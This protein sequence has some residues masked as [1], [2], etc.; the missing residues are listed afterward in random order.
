VKYFATQLKLPPEKLKP[1]YE[2]RGAGFKW[3]LAG[4]A[5]SEEFLFGGIWDYSAVPARWKAQ[6]IGFR[7]VKDA[8]APAH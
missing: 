7:C 3:P 8:A 2:I 5:K 6:D 4:K 1:W